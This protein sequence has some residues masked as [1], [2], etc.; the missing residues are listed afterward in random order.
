MEA[1]WASNLFHTFFQRYV[2]EVGFGVDVGPPRPVS[3]MAIVVSRLGYVHSARS[4]P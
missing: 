2:V 3:C 1:I 4:S